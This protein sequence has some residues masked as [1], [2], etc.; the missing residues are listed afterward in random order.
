MISNIHKKSISI[1]FK[2][3][4]GESRNY[5]H[6]L[7]EIYKKLEFYEFVRFIISGE[8]NDHD[9]KMLESLIHRYCRAAGYATYKID[10]SSSESEYADLI[11]P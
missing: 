4:P 10:F 1:L 5:L 7:K 11:F 3:S 6:V 2:N 9:N 8:R